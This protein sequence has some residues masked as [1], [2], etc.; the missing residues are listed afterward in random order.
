MTEFKQKIM[1]TERLLFVVHRGTVSGRPAGIVGHNYSIP[2][3]CSHHSWK[4]NPQ[5]IP[6]AEAGFFALWEAMGDVEA[7]FEHLSI[8]S[9]EA[10][11]DKNP[12]GLYVYEV[13]YELPGDDDDDES[14]DH[15]ADGKL[16]RPTI[17]ELNPFVHGEAPWGGVVL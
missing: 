15:L 11:G 10:H 12:Q 4:D 17:E 2:I 14:W 3:A 6:Y 7:F 8:S 13:N 9:I 5:N 1:Q 16:R